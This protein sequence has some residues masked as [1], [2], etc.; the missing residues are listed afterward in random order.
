MIVINQLKR[1]DQNNKKR[2]RNLALFLNKLDKK[3]FRTDFILEGSSNYAFPLV[4][5]EP[6]FQFRDK[7][8]SHMKKNGVEFRRGNA[9][10]GNQIR[11][12]YL[13]DIVKDKEWENKE[14]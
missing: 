4:L 8:E 1:L 12:P 5:M 14:R 13:R 2:N 6:D 11:Q 9:G 3:R 7:L 10:G